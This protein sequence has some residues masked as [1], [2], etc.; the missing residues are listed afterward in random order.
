MLVPF[1]ANKFGLWA[2]GSSNYSRPARYARATV[3]DRYS[4]GG[5]TS[6]VFWVG[7]F[8]QKGNVIAVYEW[9]GNLFPLGR[10]RQLW[11]IFKNPRFIGRRHRA[12]HRR[13]ADQAYYRGRGGQDDTRVSL[14]LEFRLNSQGQRLDGRL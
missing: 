12:N 11:R 9:D 14:A 7:R 6:T 10:F 1:T 13:Y 3:R 5:I 8:L 2:L 4:W